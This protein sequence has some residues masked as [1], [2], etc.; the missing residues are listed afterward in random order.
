MNNS[1]AQPIV[2]MSASA[3]GVNAIHELASSAARNFPVPIFFVQHIVA[4]RS[5]LSCMVSAQGPNLAVTA[6]DSD[7]PRP[8]TVHIVPPDP[9]RALDRP[10]IRLSRGPRENPAHLAID[11]LLR[12]A[13]LSCG[14]C[15]IAGGLTS[16]RVFQDKDAVLRWLVQARQATLP[17]TARES[18]ARG[19]HAMT[20]KRKAIPGLTK[21]APG[22]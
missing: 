14:P 15:T 20:N 4:H 9:Q 17:D 18:A 2:V 1:T 16:L 5:E 10:A 7:V 8:K 12:S 3:G 19:R 11:P 13:M 6:S 22:I 21:S